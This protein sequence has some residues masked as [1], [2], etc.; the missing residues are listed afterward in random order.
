MPY[1]PLAIL[2]LMTVVPAFFLGTFL[3][4][5]RKGTP[6]HKS[7]GKVY[8]GLMMVTGCITL[9]M[10]AQVGPRLFNHFG[11]IRS[12]SVLALYSAP[13]AILAIR[14]GNLK[15]HRSRM[16]G[17]YIGGILIAGGFA[18]APG[19]MLND[20]LFGTVTAV[21]TDTVASAQAVEQR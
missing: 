15:A 8:L 14:K 16:I 12:F 11:F 7:L 3:L 5:R 21:E 2:H 18:F 9:L 10:P 6:V 20:W 13:T 17:L 1:E 19:R 4:A